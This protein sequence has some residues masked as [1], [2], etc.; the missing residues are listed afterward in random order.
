MAQSGINSLKTAPQM[1]FVTCPSQ[2]VAM[3]LA[4]MLLE[5][6]LIAC[7]NLIAGVTSVYRWE[8]QVCKDTEVLMVIKT[9][10]ACFDEV[11]TI[12]EKNHPYDVPE[13][14]AVDITAG[15]P[16]YLSWLSESVHSG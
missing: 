16:A 13:V 9:T 7:A 11:K 2:E 4:E 6:K 8:G 3:G 1:V 10:D 12:V 14:V 5:Q 15:S